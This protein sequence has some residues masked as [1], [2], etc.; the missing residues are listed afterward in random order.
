MMEK[1][2][3]PVSPS[4]SPAPSVTERLTPPQ[5][6]SP[7]ASSP[8]AN[9]AN[10]VDSGAR[11][12]PS[13]PAVTE[14]TSEPASKSAEPINNQDKP[15]TPPLLPGSKH[16]TS[17]TTTIITTNTTTTTT[18]VLSSPSTSAPAP[19]PPNIPV[20][21]LAHSKPPMPPIPM[22][23]PQLTALHPIPN[24]PHGPG[25][26]R[27]AQLASLSG[28]SPTT[29]VPPPGTLLQ[30]QYLPGHPLLNSSFLGHSGGY[31]I[32]SNNRIKRRPSS[33][34]ELELT[35]CPP[36]K[37]ARR[38]FT[39]SRERWRQQ[40]VNG[41]FSELRKLIPT[42]PPD[43]KLSKNEILRL[44][45]KYI[46]FLVK[47]L[48]DQASEK[49]THG[50]MDGLEE[51]EGK[52]MKD[53]GLGNRDRDCGHDLRVLGPDS[54]PPSQISLSAVRPAMATTGRNRDSTDSVVALTTSPGSSCYGDTDSEETP[55]IQNS[56]MIKTGMSGGMMEK[57]KEQIQSV[58]A[59]GYQR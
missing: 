19:L 59:S 2:G 29:T 41:A 6:V 17:P 36:Q 28:T 44:A 8:A 31:G 57:M 43:K 23:T 49:A 50:L 58:T 39:N 16:T 20:I 47:L 24:L 30:H 46:N 55:G 3:P 4:P 22:P 37:I 56:G 14:D 13:S 7:C 5:D 26:L 53:K 11:T 10:H 35:E 1:L 21:S 25:E 38:V 52:T 9:E 54:T 48:N 51:V 42:H 40:N 12:I 32:F 27:L 33:H 15:T 45:M 18:I 34:F